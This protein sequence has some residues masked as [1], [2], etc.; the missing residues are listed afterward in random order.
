MVRCQRKPWRWCSLSPFTGAMP[1]SARHRR[2]LEGSACCPRCFSCKF[3]GEH[4]SRWHGLN[5]DGTL[6]FLAKV[7]WRDL[8]V[9]KIQLRR[10]QTKLDLESYAY[11]RPWDELRL[12]ATSSFDKELSATYVRT[13]KFQQVCVSRALHLLNH[14]ASLAHVLESPRDDQDQG[15][16]LLPVHSSR[17]E[18]SG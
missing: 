10:V 11:D 16:W 12:S 5:M 2:L 3:C 17:S 18:A 14:E 15:S 7:C 9:L 4:M 8:T 6:R 13:D 1:I